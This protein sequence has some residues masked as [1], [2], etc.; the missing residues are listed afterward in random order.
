MSC[1]KL[2]LRFVV[3]AL[4]VQVMIWNRM[5]PLMMKLE[6]SIKIII[7]FRL[8]YTCPLLESYNKYELLLR[9]AISSFTMFCYIL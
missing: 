1:Y 4:V 8:S 7:P 3:A 2:T 6:N 9:T 5:R